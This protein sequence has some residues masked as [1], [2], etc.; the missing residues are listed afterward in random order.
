MRTLLRRKEE[1]P[2]HARATN[3]RSCCRGYK[4]VSS[5]CVT[6]DFLYGSLIYITWQSLKS[7]CP[8]RAAFDDCIAHVFSRENWVEQ[9]EN[10]FHYSMMVRILHETLR[11]PWHKEIKEIII[12]MMVQ[13]HPRKRLNDDELPV[14]S[15]FSLLLQSIHLFNS[16]VVFQR[17]CIL[18]FCGITIKLPLPSHGQ[19]GFG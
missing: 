7:E 13:N 19:L 17:H 3:E 18:L 12:M 10:M 8:A 9:R 5:E 6:H 16:M 1:F 15:Q 14:K 2:E 4:I 11:S